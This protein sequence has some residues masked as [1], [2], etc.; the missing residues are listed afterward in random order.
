MLVTEPGKKELA[1]SSGDVGKILFLALSFYLVFGFSNVS[2]FLPVYYKQIGVESTDRVGLL[3]GAFYLASVLTRP[4]LGGVVERLGFKR[5]F[6]LAGFLSV[7]SSIGIAASGS[8]FWPGLICRFILGVG[9]SLFQIG[10]ATY[11]ALAFRPER[12]GR[13]FSLIMAGG[14]APVMTLVPIADILLHHSRNTLY[15]LFPLLIC[16]G[17]SLTTPLI[18]GL[19]HVTP[20]RRESGSSLSELWACLRIKPLVLALLSSFLFSVTDAAA[21]FMGSMSTRLELMASL[22]LSSNAVVGVLI[23]LTCGGLVDRFH[24][25][26]MAS[27]SI[28]VTAG[29]LLLASIFPGERA[30]VAFGMIYGIGM[31]LGFPLHLALVSDSVS[32][33][34]QPQAVSLSWFLMGVGFFVVPLSLGY[35]ESIFDPVVA[36]RMVVV[37]VLLGAVCLFFL[38]RVF[39][40]TTRRG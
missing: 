25:G 19:D 17:A 1:G 26:T 35:L 31:G 15:I 30:F 33:R 11:Q 27:V 24:R 23:R 38:W 9:S 39:I 2:Y 36:F 8:V 12:R 28:V 37:P 29:S 7:A 20:E 13:A 34:L 16:A 4:F 5:L 32:W 22:F 10:L 6:Y 40:G 3:V 18:P 14:L 21:S